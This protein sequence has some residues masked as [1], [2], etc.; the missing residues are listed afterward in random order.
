LRTFALG[1][2]AAHS[3]EPLMQPL[4]AERG[5][6]AP[7]TV[8]GVLESRTHLLSRY[9]NEAYAER[10]RAFVTD[11]RTRVSALNLEGADAFVRQV[12]LTLARLMAY[13]DE[14]EVARLYADPLF[15]QRL[16]E[17]FA[18]DLKL[19]F[20]LA[21]PLLPGRDA[22]GRPRKR[23]FGAW[24]LPVFRVLASLKGLRGTPFDPFGYTAER[25]MERRLID[26]YR[27]LIEG[28]VGQLR[29][30]NLDS[31]VQI[32][33]AA[34]RIAGYGPVKEASLAEY[35][36]RLDGLLNVFEG[37]PVGSAQ[38]AAANWR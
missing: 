31:A 14:Y 24:M 34:A 20:H 6:S 13:K 30:E 29:R 27:R 26:E 4:E 16:R 11:V 38:I 19:R 23:S 28:L 18:G 5:P 33:A 36:A 37:A 7:L 15:T 17:Q 35:R 9:Q 25:R 21:P 22:A 10:F 32:A 3:P 8:D 12:A 2:L 1:R